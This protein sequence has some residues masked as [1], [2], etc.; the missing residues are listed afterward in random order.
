MFETHFQ[1]SLRLGCHC[2]IYG[3]M[4]SSTGVN[5]TLQLRAENQR[6]IREAIKATVGFE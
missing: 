3:I 5:S 2:A 1:L 6:D 4:Y